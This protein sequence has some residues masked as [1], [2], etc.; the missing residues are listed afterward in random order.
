MYLNEPSIF[1][2][3]AKKD[4][5]ESVRVGV[6]RGVSYTTLCVNF[7]WLQPLYVFDDFN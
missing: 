5:L 4:F 7:T 3:Y 2:K 1:F 6:V